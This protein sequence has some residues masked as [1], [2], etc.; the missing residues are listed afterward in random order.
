MHPEFEDLEERLKRSLD[1]HGSVTFAAFK[2][3]ATFFDG[4]EDEYEDDEERAT[5][6]YAYYN[7]DL[8]S[9]I[10]KRA[11]LWEELDELRFIPRDQIRRHYPTQVPGFSPADYAED[12]PMIV[13]PDEILRTDLQAVAWTQRALASIEPSEHLLVANPHFGV[14]TAEE[15]VGYRYSR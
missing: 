9:T 12:L 11:E 14:P 8:W 2:A 5:A 6:L 1:F 15:V 3:C 7:G 10:M 13:S 4:E